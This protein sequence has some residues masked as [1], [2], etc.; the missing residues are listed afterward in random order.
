MPS[1]LTGLFRTL[2]WNNFPTRQGNPPA[3]GM[4][5]TAAFTDTDMQ[6]SGIFLDPVSRS[7]PTRFRLRDSVSVEINF[8]RASSFKMSWVAGRPQ[9]FQIDLLNHEQGHY[10]ITA[11]VARDFFVDV[12]L[13]KQQTFSTTQ[14]GTSAFRA[15]E[16]S[17]V[18]KIQAIH[19]LYD[20]EVHPEQHAGRSR[21]PVQQV[22]DR[23]FQTAFT[24]ARTPA[25]QSPDGKPHKVR[26]I[27]VLRQNGKSV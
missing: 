27:D 21:G 22:W 23:C 10:N 26:L 25:T 16:D 2:T 19:D 7:G 9:Q 8:K 1:S 17:S 18:K 12:M 4:H 11:L 6:Q 13:L 14:L 15:I 20:G 24:Q 3:P 5:A